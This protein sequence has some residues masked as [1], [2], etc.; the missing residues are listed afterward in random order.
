MFFWQSIHSGSCA[1]TSFIGRVVTIQAAR[2][3]MRRGYF[4]V[5][6]AA[7]DFGAHRHAEAECTPRLRRLFLPTF[8][9]KTEKVGL[10]SYS[11]DAANMWASAPTGA[12]VIVSMGGCRHPPLQDAAKS[13][14]WAHSEIRAHSVVRAY[15]PTQKRSKIRFVISSRTTLP[16]TS[17]MAVMAS[18]TSVRTASGVIPARIE[19]SA[20][21]MAFPARAS[22]EA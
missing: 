9:G 12:V 5:V 4:C 7:L 2:S 6:A 15:L 3:S 11:T 19:P 17:P 13:R 16:V 1:A 20:D 22:A 18:S 14:V 10:R 8:S 21:S